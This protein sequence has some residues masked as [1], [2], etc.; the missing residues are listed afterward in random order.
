MSAVLQFES[1][2]FQWYQIHIGLYDELSKDIDDF[3]HI[4]GKTYIKGVNLLFEEGLFGKMQ[5]MSH[6]F[7][8]SAQVTFVVRI[9]CRFDRNIL[10][11]F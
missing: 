10:T 5:C 8:L 4:R 9:G 6:P 2:F 11:D 7:F 1:T 3:V